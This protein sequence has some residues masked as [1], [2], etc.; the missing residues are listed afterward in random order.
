MKKKQYAFWQYDLYPYTLG[1]EILKFSKNSLCVHVKGYEGWSFQPFL[2]VD[3]A[4]GALLLKEIEALREWYSEER[5]KLKDIFN[6]RLFDVI[7]DHPYNKKNLN[8]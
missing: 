6:K 1:G 8:K 7:P 5:A 3:G 2:I 4:K